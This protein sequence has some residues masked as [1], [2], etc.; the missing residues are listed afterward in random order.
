[1]IKKILVVAGLFYVVWFSQM[2]LEV[3][4]PFPSESHFEVWLN[5]ENKSIAEVANGILTI[6][7]YLVWMIFVAALVKFTPPVVRFLLPL[8]R[9]FGTTKFVRRMQGF[10]VELSIIILLMLSLGAL[11]VVYPTIQDYNKAV[12]KQESILTED[13]Y[14]NLANAEYKLKDEIQLNRQTAKVWIRSTSSMYFAPKGIWPMDNSKT[15]GEY[16]TDTELGKLPVLTSWFSEARAALSNWFSK[17]EGG[18]IQDIR[19]SSDYQT[20][21]LN[22]KET[23]RK[24][25]KIQEGT[26]PVEAIHKS[27]KNIVLKISGNP[28]QNTLDFFKEAMIWILPTALVL[29]ILQ[30]LFVKRSGVGRIHERVNHFLQKGRFGGGGSARIAGLFEEWTELFKHQKSGLYMGRSLYS[31]FTTIGL[32]D[33]RHMLTVAGTRGGKGSSVIIPNLLLHQDSVLVVDPKGTNTLVTARARREMGQTVHTI[34]PFGIT[35]ETNLASF[36]VLDELNLNSQTIREEVIRIAEALIVRTGKE[37]DP[38]WDDSAEQILSGYITHLISSPDYVD[39]NLSMLKGMFHLVGEKR[40]TLWAKMALN[41]AAGGLAQEAAHRMIELEGSNELKSFFSSLSKHISWLSSPSLVRT[42]KDSTFRFSD[43]KNA[44]TTVYLVLPPYLLKL[45][46]RFLRLFIN[47]F[48]NQMSIGGKAKVPVLVMMDEFLALGRMRELQEAFPLMAGYNMVMWPFVQNMNGLEELYGKDGADAF[49]SNVRAIQVFSLTGGSTARFVSDQLGKARSTR[50]EDQTELL[51]E[52]DEVT[53]EVA[54]ENKKQYILR[55][56]KPALILERVAYYESATP[57]LD[58]ILN[59]R[60]MSELIQSVP[61]LAFL[62][63]F[64]SKFHGK[65]D[66]DPDYLE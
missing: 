60:V 37:K 23:V 27:A 12:K 38:H 1:M 42:M 57:W 11:F 19:K 15:I 33:P 8:S 4:L 53:A 41:E 16:S 44:P 50:K 66:S 7:R 26:L 39:P 2:F 62:K 40:N 6:C 63:R 45:H 20:F 59:G 47:S 61:R 13:Y 28:V 52:P 32:E 34:D 30:R 25:Q 21:F 58:K 29:Y 17:S 56:G 18:V 64:G 10:N 43:L 5:S 51:R 49:V 22:Q 46:N 35:G 14:R 55:A 24:L 65:Y 36:N 54:K 31:P 9:R 3:I 48:L